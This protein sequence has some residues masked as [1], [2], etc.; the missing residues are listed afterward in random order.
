[1]PPIESCVGDLLSVAFGV[2]VLVSAWSILQRDIPWL[3]VGMVTVF[4]SLVYGLMI[5]PHASV[6]EREP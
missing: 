1:M 2:T 3:R 5:G 4:E 6:A